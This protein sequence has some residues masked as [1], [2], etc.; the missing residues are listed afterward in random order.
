MKKKQF[1]KKGAKI[2]VRGEVEAKWIETDKNKMEN[3]GVASAPGL[4]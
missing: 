4:G 3:S 2:A 1:Q